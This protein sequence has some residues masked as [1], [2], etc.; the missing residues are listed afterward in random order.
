MNQTFDAIVIGAGV[1]GASTAFHLV[2]RGLKTAILERRVTA[3][4]ATGHSS[5]RH[6]LDGVG[7]SRV[8]HFGRPTRAK[9]WTI[10]RHRCEAGRY[11][12]SDQ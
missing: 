7:S 4:G 10:D 3:S 5:D 11:C 1:M 8:P 9:A 2:E 6:S 12:L